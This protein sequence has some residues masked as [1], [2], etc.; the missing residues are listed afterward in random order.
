MGWSTHQLAAQNCSC[1][2]SH[3]TMQALGSGL[4]PNPHLRVGPVLQVPPTELSPCLVLFVLSFS[5]LPK[6]GTWHFSPAEWPLHHF[7]TPLIQVLEVGLEAV[8]MP[9]VLAHG[10]AQSPAITSLPTCT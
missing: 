10:H 2:I 9:E 1:A 5:A 3:P 8:V 7:P 6:I 4:A